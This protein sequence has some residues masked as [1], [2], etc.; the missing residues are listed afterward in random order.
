MKIIDLL[1]ESSIELNGRT[2]SKEELID[3]LVDLMDKSQV[4]VDK[5]IYKSDVLKRESSSTTGIGEGVAIP[6]AKSKGVKTPHLAAMIIK[7]GADFD[8]LDGEL[9]HL[10]FMI[11]VPEKAS[12]DHI[13]LLQRLSTM[14]MDADF[15]NTLI[16]A[17]STDEFL[18]IIE[19]K[20]I[21]KF[22]NDFEAKDSNSTYDILAITG[23]PT[24]I[25]H[26]FMAKESLENKAKDL[27][28]TIK[29]ETHGSTG[30]ENALTKEEIDK[31]KGIIIASDVGVEKSRFSGKRLVET[32][33]S[34]GIN[35]PKDLIDLIINEKAPVYKSDKKSEVKEEKPTSS[36]GQTIYKHLMNGVSH[37][38][39]FVVGGGIL[40][41]LAFLL[42]D[43]TI[44]PAN[45]GSNTPIAAIF[46]KIGGAAF[47][48]MLPILSGFIAMS[49]ADRPG[50]TVGFVGGFLANEGG[51]G[52]LG[53]L[54]AGFLSGLIIILLRKITKP[55]PKSMDGLKPILI[56]PLVG[57]LAIGLIMLLLLN[58]PLAELNL[59]ITNFLNNM[60]SASKI[61]LGLLVGGMM[62]I[63]MGGPINKAAYIFGTASLAE[64]SSMIMAAVMAGGMVPPLALAISMIIFKNKYTDKERQTIP[65]NIIMGLSFITEGAIPFAA[66]D[67]LRVIPASVVGS[68]IAGMLSMIFSC[69]LRAPHGGMWVIGVIDNPLFY[70]LS[71]LVGS[72]V[73][74]LILGLVKK[75]TNKIR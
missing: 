44:D 40:I 13:I 29:V 39:P 1:S 9:S 48:F 4:L 64:G 53:A 47:G 45:F 71:I 25:A 19:A 73:G 16:G 66:A 7:E 38:L 8:S 70:I 20:E 50:L 49:I 24:G 35:K 65:T 68:A 41:A 22:P 11:A 15:R 18:K 62:A 26:T 23:C 5:E 10:F 30:I 37:M 75:D 43:Y 59:S 6:H 72:I 54:I 55:L 42:D 58:P 52:F 31:A 46:N 67:P 33:V 74:A 3:R 32:K 56:F 57:I 14:L 60:G 69:A 21:E 2:G 17:K 63:D 36:L 27:G 51:A 12:D 61:V 34:D 28:Y